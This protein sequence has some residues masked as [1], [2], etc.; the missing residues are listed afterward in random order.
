MSDVPV[1]AVNGEI[2]PQDPPTN[3]ADAAAVWPNSLTLTVPG[4]GHDID[5][6]SAGCV[7]PLIQSF[8]DQGDAADLDVTCLTQLPPPAFDLTLP[9]N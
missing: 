5:P 1:L 9:T 7:I 2:D 6:V 8:I 4:Q 3:M